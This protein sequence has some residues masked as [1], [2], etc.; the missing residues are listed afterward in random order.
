[1]VM[2]IIVDR[3]WI[4]EER[5]SYLDVRSTFGLTAVASF[6]AEIDVLRDEKRVSGRGTRVVS[7]M[8][9]YLLGLGRERVVVDLS[10]DVRKFGDSM[11]GALAWTR[12]L[13]RVRPAVTQSGM[14]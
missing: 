4:K 5:G 11:V 14:G 10:P 2:V 6:A 7:N 8:E 12:G 13:Y 1:M 3:Q 9:R